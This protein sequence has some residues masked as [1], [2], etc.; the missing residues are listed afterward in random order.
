M[1]S[2]LNGCPH[3]FVFFLISFFLKL[4]VAYSLCVIYVKDDD[5]FNV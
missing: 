2:Q 4:I 3:F 1:T 5:D